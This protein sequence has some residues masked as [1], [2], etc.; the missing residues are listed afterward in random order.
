MYDK[1]RSEKF[2]FIPD[3]SKSFNF[4]NEKLYNGVITKNILSDFNI[5]RER[6]KSKEIIFYFGEA[7][8]RKGYDLLIKLV[9]I[10]KD[11]VFVLCGEVPDYIKNNRELEAIK[12]RLISK[13][14]LF[15]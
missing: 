6:N 11:L 8:F 9:E 1:I 14:N 12:L 3:I 5:F 2:G 15:Y 10:N 13:T 7:N 4:R